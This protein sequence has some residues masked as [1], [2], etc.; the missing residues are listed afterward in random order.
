MSVHINFLVDAQ[1]PFFETRICKVRKEEE[2]PTPYPDVT[3]RQYVTYI[4][5]SSKH[6]EFNE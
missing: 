6:N 5:F 1:K 4:L 3:Q 2:L